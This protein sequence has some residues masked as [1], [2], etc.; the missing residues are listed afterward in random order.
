MAFKQR[1]REVTLVEVVRVI[2][3]SVERPSGVEYKLMGDSLNLYLAE[4]GVKGAEDLKE[5]MNN[6]LRTVIA[7]IDKRKSSS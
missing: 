1:R 6:G 2:G 5:V 7:F 3:D 4:M